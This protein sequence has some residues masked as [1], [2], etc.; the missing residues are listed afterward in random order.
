MDEQVVTVTPGENV[1]VVCAV[2]AFP[3]PDRFSWS[4]NSTQDGLQAV[5]KSEVSLL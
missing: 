5:P 4:L 2:D 3:P 1:T